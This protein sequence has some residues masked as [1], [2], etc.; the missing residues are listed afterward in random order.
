MPGDPRPP[1]RRGGSL[2]SVLA[3]SALA[4]V[5]VVLLVGVLILAFGENEDS[6]EAGAPTAAVAT[7]S[8]APT[9]QLTPT[10]LASPPPSA[11]PS[12]SPSRSP[13]PSATPSVARPS[14][15]VLNQTVVTGLAAKVRDRLEAGGWTVTGIDDFRGNVPA[16]TVYYPPGLQAA[17]RALMA[18]FPE[19]GRIRPAFPGISTTQLTV[20]LGKDF[21]TAG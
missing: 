18:Q 7:P 19:I 4:A 13:R 21:P 14:V 2:L 15:V 16:T 17:A 6:T 12:P 20:I 1:G 11:S 10:P 3:S 5:A 8:P 9:L